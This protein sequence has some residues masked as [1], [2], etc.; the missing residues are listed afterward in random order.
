MNSKIKIPRN[1]NRL[2]VEMLIAT[3]LDRIGDALHVFK[4]DCGGYLALNLRTGKYACL[5][6]EMLRDPQVCRITEIV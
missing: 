6:G 1:F 4:N 5:F 3:N 2:T